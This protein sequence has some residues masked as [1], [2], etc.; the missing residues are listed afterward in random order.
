MLSDY[1]LG[2]DLGRLCRIVAL[3]DDITDF[4]VAHDEVYAVGGQG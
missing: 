1:Q 2:D 4:L 3:V